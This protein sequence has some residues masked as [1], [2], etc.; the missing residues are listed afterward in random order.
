MNK[1]CVALFA[2]EMKSI[3]LAPSS[4]LL[5]EERSSCIH[6]REKLSNEYKG[7]GG[8]E[9]D[10]EKERKDNWKEAQSSRL[11]SLSRFQA[12]RWWRHT[13]LESPVNV[14]GLKSNF[15]QHK[16]NKAWVLANKPVHFVQ[17]TDISILSSGKLLK[18]LSRI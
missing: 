2:Q 10:G 4:L 3:Q 9:L 15:Q 14:S 8:G 17:L 1:G 6:R 11:S 13:F 16:E 5:P 18:S 12:L 7:G